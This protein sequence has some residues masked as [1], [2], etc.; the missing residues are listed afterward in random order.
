MQFLNRSL[1]DRR[2][3]LRAG[4]V[5]LSLPLLDAMIPIAHG[6][7]AKAKAAALRPRRMVLVHRPLGTYHPHLVPEKT[8]LDYEAT[9]FLK[10]LEP[11]RG[12]FTVFSG[13]G[14]RGYPNSHGTEPAIF[15]GVAEFHEHDLHNS[16]SLDR[17]ASSHV[18]G[19]TRFSS[20]LLNRTW[21][22]SLSWNEKGVPVP[23]EGDAARVFQRLFIEGTPEEVRRETRRLAQGKSILDDLRGELK[24]LSQRLG[25]GDRERIEVLANTIREAEQQL[26]QEEAWSK[27]PKP[28]T[29]LALDEFQK[30]AASWVGT[31]DK[32]LTLIHA[33]LQTDSTRVI[34]LATG[35]HNLNNVPG[36]EIHHHDASH[37][38]KDPAKVEQLCRYEDREF[39]TYA[40]FLDQLAATAEPDGTLLDSTQALFTSNLGDASAHSSTNLPVLLTGGGFKHQGH[41]AYRREGNEPLCNLYARMLQQFGVETDRFGSGDG[42]VGEV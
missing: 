36:L 13:M 40:R 19:E 23:H 33:A 17:I 37:H 18:A 38:G 22:Q 3:M 15:T 24:R 26:L 5:S 4:A 42:V 14:H 30:P 9:R 2:A 28:N 34:V 27:K 1:I 16:V 7:A 21:S 6:Q 31:Q 32:W 11:H 20:L 10:V 41:V 25:P 39:E 8:G 29:T 12:K 35:E